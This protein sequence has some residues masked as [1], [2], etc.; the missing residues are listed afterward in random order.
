MDTEVL[1]DL[2]EHHF[3]QAQQATELYKLRLRRTIDRLK[4]GFYLQRDELLIVDLQSVGFNDIA[5]QVR[6]GL[7]A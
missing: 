4:S 7:Y 2:L 5:Q 6:R 3:T 1:V